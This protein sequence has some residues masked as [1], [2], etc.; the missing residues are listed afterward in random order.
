VGS[1]VAFRAGLPRASGGNLAA[2]PAGD[3]S[4]NFRPEDPNDRAL[5]ELLILFEETLIEEQI[6]PADFA[7]IVAKP[8]GRAM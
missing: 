6:I 4:G 1:W 2:V 8:L 5:L 3:I 7:M